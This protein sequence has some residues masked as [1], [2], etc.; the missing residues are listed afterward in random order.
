MNNNKL[1]LFA[2]QAT[3]KAVSPALSVDDTFRIESAG[4][5]SMWP[6]GHHCIFVYL[7]LC[8][9]LKYLG[10]ILEQLLY[11]LDVAVIAG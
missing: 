11:H 7:I 3:C 6:A 10:P 2:W 8:L 5:D 4:I 9:C 1:H